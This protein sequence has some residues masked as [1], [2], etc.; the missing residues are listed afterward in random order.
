MRPLT[1]GSDVWRISAAAPGDV[2]RV[3]S[4]TFA[5]L[6]VAQQF[7]RESGGMFDPCR[8]IRSGRLGDLELL[9]PDGVVCRAPVALDLGGI[10]KGF[11]VDRAIDA[12][13]RHG[14]TRGVVNAGGDLRCFGP[15][16]FRVLLRPPKSGGEEALRLDLADCALAVSADRSETSPSEHVGY[17]VGTT[18]EPA[19]GRWTAVTAPDAVVADAMCKCA[20][21]GPSHMVSELLRVHGA[22][23]VRAAS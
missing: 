3:D 13:K 12:L 1:V 6:E 9:A 15:A 7:H 2:V 10:A 5:V 8:P 14:C 20:M 17:Y 18:G 19:E 22:R 16:P 11:A 23:L 21:L 4:W